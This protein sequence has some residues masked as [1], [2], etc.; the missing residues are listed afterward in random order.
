METSIFIAKL[1]GPVLI[2][3]GLLGLFRPGEMKRLAEDFLAS[4]P[5]IFGAGFLAL[6]GGLAIVNTHNVWT[7]D[8]RVVITLLGWV[9]MVAGILRMGFPNTIRKIGTLMIDRPVVLRVA[10]GI[11]LAVGAWLMSKSY[12]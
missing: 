9:S 11:Q 3:G 5:L 8:W 7:D 1:V 10:G 4:R 2:V 12:L 6:L